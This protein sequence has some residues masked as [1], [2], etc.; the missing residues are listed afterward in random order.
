MRSLKSLVVLMFAVASPAYAYR[1]SA[2][3]PSWD[4]S[5]PAIMGIHARDL[6]ETNP[7]WMYANPD[8]TVRLSGETAQ[9][10]S[11]LAGTLLMPTIKNYANGSF[12]GAMVTTIVN[13]DTLRAQH[14]DAIVQAVV[15]N[16]YDGVDVDYE[17]ISSGAKAGYTTFIQLLAAKLHA[18]KKQLSVTVQA[19]SSAL[20]WPAI[21][22]AADSVKIMAYD[23]HWTTS[24]AGAIAPLD[25]L[26][27]V[28][29]DAERLLGQK[30]MIGLPWYGYDWLGT[31]GV[32]VTYAQAMSKAQSAGIAVG[33]D[34]NGE[35]T[36]TYDGR[37]VFFQDAESY[38]RKV[39]SI[40]ARHGGI[41]GFAHWRVGA[42]D[43]A[44]WDVVGELHLLAGGSSPTTTI[45]PKDFRIEGPS[46]IAMIAGTES[47]T[48]FGFLGI[49]GFTGPVNL[50][51]TPLDPWS[52]TLFTNGTSLVVKTAVA[53]TYRI[54]LTMTG[55][56]ITRESVV[57][58]RVS[59]AKIAKR[60]SVH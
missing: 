18:S 13:S 28:A 44:I 36:Y 23:Y 53:G 50:S 17:R 2:W 34:A 16:G 46:E 45:P 42:E 40:I 29:A 11:A 30:A 58:L 15:Q 60:R 27:K 26:D 31:A 55:G 35:A 24:A 1:M 59:A 25:W 12:D 20:D 33:R 54:A 49:N 48:R 47:S 3:V 10:R 41:G 56:G 51:A 43:P 7:G 21:G 38:R 22:A 37:T 5:A 19:N 6:H 39:E 14:A 8:G 32:G 4:S 52:G 9:L 57:T